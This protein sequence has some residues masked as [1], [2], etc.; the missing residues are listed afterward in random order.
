M[1]SASSVFEEIFRDDEAFALFC[2][3]AASGEA[4]G[5]W[6]NGRIAALVPRVAVRT[7]RRRSPGMAPTRTS[8]G[9][10]SMRCC[11]SA[12]W[13]R[14][15]V[16]E[17]DRLHHAA[18]GSG[19]SAWPTAGCVRDEELTE[20]DIVAYLAHS[21]VT[22]QRASEQMQACCATV[23]AATGRTSRRACPDDL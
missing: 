4:Q 8:T 20:Q 19:A 18:R 9:A 5:G 6:E 1:L 2:S 14:S 17:D 16:P 13:S 21:R 10:S 15:P 7:W 3:I 23:R 22:E 12:A 11:A